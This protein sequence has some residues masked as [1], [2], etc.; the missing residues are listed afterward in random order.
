MAI[1]WAGRLNWQIRQYFMWYVLK[2]LQY[3]LSTFLETVNKTKWKIEIYYKQNQKAQ[4]QTNKQTK[5]KNTLDWDHRILIWTHA[6]QDKNRKNNVQQHI[7]WD[8]NP[9]KT[10][11]VFDL[12]P[13]CCIYMHIKEKMI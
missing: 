13:K 8:Q 7:N 9:L 12:W 11:D 2:H 3:I 5:T 1:M 4:K 10:G 6:E